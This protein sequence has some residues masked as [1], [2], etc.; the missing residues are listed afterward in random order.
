LF[1]K[2]K[3]KR[4]INSALDSARDALAL[5]QKLH[6]RD[7]TAE[8]RTRRTAYRNATTPQNLGEYE[9]AVENLMEAREYVQL[10]YDDL[11]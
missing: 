3:W 2:A 5:N 6:I 10:L 9:K 4:D 7:L 8:V 1:K 11:E